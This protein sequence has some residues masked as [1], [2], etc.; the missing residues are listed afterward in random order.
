MPPA[1]G[2]ALGIDRLLML[3]LDAPHIRDVLAFGVDGIIANVSADS[4]D[5]RAWSANC[6]RAIPDGK[7]PLMSETKPNTATMTSSIADHFSYLT[8]FVTVQYPALDWFQKV[9]CWQ[10]P[11]RAQDG[12][13]V[14]PCDGA[15]GWRVVAI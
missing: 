5:S 15:D 7:S 11:L 4:V 13:Q 1:G 6:G 9:F 2:V 3:I 8:A 14:M 10:C 12:K